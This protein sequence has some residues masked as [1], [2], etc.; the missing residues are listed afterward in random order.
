[1][2]TALEFINGRLEER[3]KAG[4]YRLLK[5]DNNLVDFCSNDYLGFARSD[6]LKSWIE[7]ETASYNI[8]SNGSTGSRLLSGNSDYAEELEAQL[9]QLFNCEAALLFGSGYDANAGL[10]SSLPQKGDTVIA[11]ELIH[12]SVIDGIRL[13][14]AARFSF[15][16]NDLG[17]LEEKLKQAKGVCYVVIES[18]YSMDGDSPDITATLALTE[19]YHAHLIVDEAHA[20]GLFGTGLAGGELAGRVFARVI[21]FGKALGCHGAAVLGSKVLKEYLVNF[22][23]SLIYTTAPSFHQLASVKM[24]CKLFSS[25][26]EQI[27]KLKNNIKLY[28]E[29]ISLYNICGTLDS[30]SAIQCILMK[31]NRQVLSASDRLCEAG[32]DV[33]AILSPT[34]ATGKE[35]LR[36]CIHNFNRKDEIRLLTKTLADINAA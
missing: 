2:N 8:I 22:A 33:R 29:C 5:P 10:L 1:M 17:S 24:A 3:H 19:K 36:I 15:R 7:A 20:T 30:D 26:R 13:S 9:A 23:R 25:A 14:F 28:K 27:Q 11:D 18:V 4:N 31:D 35:R 32:L 12:A 6:L 16:H 34:V 21:T